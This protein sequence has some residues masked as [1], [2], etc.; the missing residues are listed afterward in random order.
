VLGPAGGAAETRFVTTDED[1]A[2]RITVQA[3]SGA[4]RRVYDAQGDIAIDMRVVGQSVEIESEGRIIRGAF[5][6][7][8]GRVTITLGGEVYDIGVAPEA[9]VVAGAKAGGAGSGAVLAPMPG[10]VAEVRVAMGEAVEVGQV[11]VVLESMKLFTSLSAQVAGAIA[12]IACKPGETVPA[13]KRL[14]LI[15]PQKTP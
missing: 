4:A 5:E 2:F 7:S 9:A 8:A 1:G 12:D 6:R 13:G 15:E 3:Q 10:V 11:V 14:V